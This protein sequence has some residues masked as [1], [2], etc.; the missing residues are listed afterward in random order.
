MNFFDADASS[1][2]LGENPFPTDHPAFEAFE[3]VTFE[4]E[5]LISRFQAAM[6]RVNTSGPDDLLRYVIH[7]RIN[8]SEICAR[9]L[10]RIVEDRETE[11][12]YA[13]WLNSF[14]K[15]ELSVSTGWVKHLRCGT[16]RSLSANRLR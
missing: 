5:E 3:S 11:R 14:A 6:L 1:S 8:R 9:S 16:S 2:P 15:E 7:Y 10:L 12:I 4:A 13:H